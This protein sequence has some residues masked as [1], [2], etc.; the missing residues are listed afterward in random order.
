MCSSEQYNMLLFKGWERKL[1]GFWVH[2]DYPKLHPLTA[3]EA[4]D[5]E[6][7]H[8]TKYTSKTKKW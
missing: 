2:T 5:I 8:L 1:N 6:A 4:L 3:Q 7:D